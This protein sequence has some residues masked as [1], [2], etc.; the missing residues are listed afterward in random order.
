MSRN[1]D[2]KEDHSFMERRQ[3]ELRAEKEAEAGYYS[4]PPEVWADAW[5]KA[6][7]DSHPD[8][9]FSCHGPGGTHGCGFKTDDPD[10]A[11]QHT[12]LKGAEHRMTG[13][14]ARTPKR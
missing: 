11:A 5:E 2:F 10:A 3:A 13:I 12:E 6:W 14:V 7:H 9:Y 8:G 1:D 4:A